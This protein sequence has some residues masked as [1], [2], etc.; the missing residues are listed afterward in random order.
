MDFEYGCAITNKYSF[1]DENEVEDPSELLAQVA[2]PKGKQAKDTSSTKLAKSAQSS[3]QAS[4]S[5]L[6]QSKDGKKQP[7]Q[8]QIDNSVKLNKSATG[9]DSKKQRYIQKQSG[10][11]QHQSQLPKEDKENTSNKSERKI[12]NNPTGFKNDRRENSDH[13]RPP[14]R[15]GPR[16][17]GGFT[18]QDRPRKFREFPNENG[19]NEDGEVNDNT[20]F[21]RGPGPNTGI[22]FRGPRGQGFRN[23]RTNDSEKHREFD[24]HSGSEKT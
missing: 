21:R 23:R 3:K 14:R 22:G 4:N 9:D 2:E 17:E 13:Q 10:N 12:G 8:Q 1:L 5:K 24:R 18:N 15:S 20:G 19:Q 6:Q 16:P 11:G 7:L